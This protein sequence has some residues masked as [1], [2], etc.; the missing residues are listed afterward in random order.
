MMRRIILL[1]IV[2]MGV[3][4]FGVGQISR[5]VTTRQSDLKTA[6]ASEYNKI[7]LNNAHYTDVVGQPE[8]PVYIRSF[9]I[10]IDAQITG[11]TVNSVNKQKM[12]GTY[13][14]YP[15]QPPRPVSFNADFADFVLPDS[16]VYNSSM[17]YPGKQV[18]IISDDRYLGYRIVTVRLYPVEYIPLTK[19]LFVCSFDFSIDYSINTKQVKNNE[20]LT[21]T[22]SL[23]RYELNKKS[24]KFRVENPEVVDNYDTKVR[25]IVQGRTVVQDFSATS[26][27]TPGLRSQTAS[28]GASLAKRNLCLYQERHK[29]RFAKLAPNVS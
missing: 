10:P 22:Q 25:K 28:I 6:R 24:V 5:N 12:E 21:Q 8:L 23:Y 2:W 14:I 9:V 20:F 18:E 3:C 19:E 13:H 1:T 17:P 4:F 26:P 27:G 15:V 11:V 29:L 7:F 16:V